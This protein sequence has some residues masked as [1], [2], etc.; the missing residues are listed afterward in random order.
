MKWR[1]KDSDGS[2][3]ARTPDLRITDSK[4]ILLVRRS[5]QLSYGT[6]LVDS[7]TPRSAFILLRSAAYDYDAQLE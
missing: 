1:K 5:N 3:E 7:V 6:G 2:T 4:Y